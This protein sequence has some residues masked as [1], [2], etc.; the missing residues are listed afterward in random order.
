MMK[1]NILQIAD[2]SRTGCDYAFMNYK[3]AQ[4]HGFNITRDYKVTYTGYLTSWNEDADP[5]N[6]LEDLFCQFNQ[7]RP[8]DFHGHSL[9][10][11]DIVILHC[12]NK[13]SRF[14]YCDSFGWEE[15]I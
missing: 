5:Y 13:P 3:F 10:V 14:F 7:S 12:E 8:I 9:S 2:I 15:I 1:Y 11:S 4:S 6:I